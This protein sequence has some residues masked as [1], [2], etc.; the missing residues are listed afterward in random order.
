MSVTLA[1]LVYNELEATPFAFEAAASIAFDEACRQASPE[2]L[3]PVMSVDIFCPKDF[4]GD[5]ISLATQRG[6]LV[7]GLESKHATE[8]VHAKAPMAKMFGFST[9]LR[10]VTQGRGSFSMEFSHFEVKKGGI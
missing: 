7:S 2:L 8:I 9:A 1:S 4:V 5:A 6:G 3:E 10:S